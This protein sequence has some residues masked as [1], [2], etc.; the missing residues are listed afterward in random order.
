MVFKAISEYDSHSQQD[1]EAFSVVTSFNEI[2]NRQ[3]ILP[4]Q[5][6][7]NEVLIIT[8]PHYHYLLQLQL[9]NYH[10]SGN[11]FVMN[12]PIDK[13]VIRFHTFVILFT[14]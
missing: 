9:I 6:N 1:V 12:Q 2:Y 3:I 4:D 7:Y 5:G 10:F 14:L 11:I 8:Y 13:I